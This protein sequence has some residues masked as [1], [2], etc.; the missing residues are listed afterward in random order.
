MDK[1]PL[2]AT[3]VQQAWT[4]LLP[5]H[6]F[7]LLEKQTGNDDGN[8]LETEGEKEINKNN[9]V[10][11]AGDLRTGGKNKRPGILIHTFGEGFLND[12]SFR[13]PKLGSFISL[14]FNPNLPG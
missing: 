1:M 2:L 12:C 11:T 6:A 3:L 14:W 9:K 4:C 13:S 7:I 5:G 8:H 10:I